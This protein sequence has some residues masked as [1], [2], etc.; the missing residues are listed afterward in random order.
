M[1]ADS[2]RPAT[3]CQ[4]GVCEPAIA[5]W[6]RNREIAHAQFK[7]LT[8]QRAA[9]SLK[10]RKAAVMLHEPFAPL[11]FIDHNGLNEL[12]VA[13]P[14]GNKRS[15][16]NYRGDP[17][18]PDCLGPL[19]EQVR[20]TLARKGYY[21]ARDPVAVGDVGMLLHGGESELSGGCR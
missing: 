16:E 3:T 20:I 8:L 18:H 4:R 13:W 10:G 6:I 1:A 9:S 5:T 21:D 2:I 7:S 11:R 17:I 19:V 12:L 15:V 14:N